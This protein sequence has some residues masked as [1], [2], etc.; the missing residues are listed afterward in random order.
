MPGET[1]MGRMLRLCEERGL[2]AV[3]I[4]TSYGR[5]AL[6][7]ARRSFAAV[8]NPGE[9][10][11][12]CPLEHKELLMEMAPDLYWQ[13]EHFRG[14]PGLLVRLDAISDEELGLR[15][16]DAWRFRA[17]GRLQKSFAAGRRA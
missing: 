15:L 9:M 3:K 6:L 5:P 7:V 11:L 10:V 17:P 12:H 8:R 2:P 1:D 4:G 13:T 16:E 14:W